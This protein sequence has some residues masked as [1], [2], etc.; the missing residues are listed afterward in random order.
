MDR[1]AEEIVFTEDGCSFC[2]LALKNK[3]TDTNVPDMYTGE[4]YDV[5]LGLSGGV[6]S[7]MCL[8][9]VVNDLNLKPL[10]FTIDTGYNKPDADENI[11]KMVEKLR[12]PFFRYTIDLVKFRELQTAFLMS[13]TKNVEIPTDHVLYAALLDVA[14]KYNIK[15]II[16][17][18][19]WNTESIMPRSW[20]YQPRD[21]VHIKDV[22]RKHLHKELSGLPTC[23][24]LKWNYLKWIKGLKTVNLLDY[25]DYNRDKAIEFL[26]KEYGF[27]DTGEKHCENYFTWWF[28]NYY[29]FEKFGI[30]KRKAHYSSLILSGQ[31][32]REE[33]MEKIAENPVYPHMGIEQKVMKYPKRDY[34]EYKNDEKR[35]ETISKVI[36]ALRWR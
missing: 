13:G 27:K 16:S 11:L 9:Y 15:T 4:E 26:G 10:T 36:K 20:G 18:G 8:H 17:G 32:T 30:D 12:V 1:T 33:A 22:Y 24:L 34:T 29:L 25:Y 35:F 7:A 14:N 28:Q 3:P 21:L 23:G 19:N 31:M 5:V 2:E 6:D